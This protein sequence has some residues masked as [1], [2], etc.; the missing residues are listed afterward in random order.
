M[1][2][3][4][5]FSYA[6]A[7]DELNT[8]LHFEWDGDITGEIKVLTD[9][10]K[11]V[12][13]IP[14]HGTPPNSIKTELKARNFPSLMVRYSPAPKASWTMNTLA[15]FQYICDEWVLE[16]RGEFVR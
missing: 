4:A 9:E 14:L 1:T 7:D 10:T 11:E 2:N 5:H 15:V 3:A 12:G 16:H 13:S 8:I 6:Y